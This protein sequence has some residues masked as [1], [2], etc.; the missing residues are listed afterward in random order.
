[1]LQGS[2]I[3]TDVLHAIDS[4]RG[5]H[6][7]FSIQDSALRWPA[8]G[9]F[10]HSSFRLWSPT[11]RSAQNF[12][13]WD[14]NSGS[15]LHTVLTPLLEKG[16]TRTCKGTEDWLHR[17]RASHKVRETD[18]CLNSF[19]PPKSTPVTSVSRFRIRANFLMFMCN[20]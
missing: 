15:G 16:G 13:V 19:F 4:G 1:M 20:E 6:S 17:H 12:F 9:N 2:R 14:W 18:T 11:W 7:C 5:T 8:E 3:D 10:S